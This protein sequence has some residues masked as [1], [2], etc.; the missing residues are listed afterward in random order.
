[1]VNACCVRA[2][3]LIWVIIVPF[4]ETF[5]SLKQKVGLVRAD[6]FFSNGFMEYCEESQLHHGSQVYKPIK[7]EVFRQKAWVVP[8]MHRN[9]RMVLSTPDGPPRRMIAIQN[10]SKHP[11]SIGSSPL[12]W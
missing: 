11:K 3:L 7:N 6:G 8:T 5:H 2:I 1:V 12:E 9:N 4:D 10:L